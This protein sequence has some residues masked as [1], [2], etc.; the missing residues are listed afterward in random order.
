MQGTVVTRFWDQIEPM[1]DD[2]GCWEWAGT[3]NQ[4]GYGRVWSSETGRVLAHRF[5]WMLHFGD[6]PA[7]KCVCHHCDNPA[8]VNPGHLFLGTHLDNMQDRTRKGRTNPLPGL[9]VAHEN[10]RTRMANRTHCKNGHP[11]EPNASNA[12]RICSNESALRS[13][14]KFKALG[15]RRCAS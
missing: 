11:W 13:Y 14:Y 5:S 6:V 1:L 8:C 7:G 9:R 3:P 10:G 12:C 4:S 15:R 2:R